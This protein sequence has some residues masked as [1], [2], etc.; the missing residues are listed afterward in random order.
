[1]RMNRWEFPML[2]A[3]SI[4]DCRLCPSIVIWNSRYS[5]GPCGSFCH[6]C[7]KVHVKSCTACAQKYPEAVTPRFGCPNCGSEKLNENNVVQVRLPIMAWDSN[8]RP[9]D[10]GTGWRE[11]E[12]TIRAVK[13]NEGPRY[14]CDDCKE[15]FDE[16]SPIAAPTAAPAPA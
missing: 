4:W 10:F 2:L 13:K 11:V 1:M 8:G 9:V 12:D 7:I 6:D 5:Q 3:S 15:E 16:V 14:Q